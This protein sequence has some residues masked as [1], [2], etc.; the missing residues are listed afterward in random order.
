MLTSILVF[1]VVLALVYYLI[2]LLPIPSPF[3]QII[4][5]IFILIA[6]LYL[7]E[8]FGLFSTNLI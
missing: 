4:N 6:I 2:S 1:L 5:V 7:L 3:N 8:K